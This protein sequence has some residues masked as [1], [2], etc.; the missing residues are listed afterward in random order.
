VNCWKIRIHHPGLCFAAGDTTSWRWWRWYCLLQGCFPPLLR[1]IP[2]AA[3]VLWG[4]IPAPFQHALP[5]NIKSL[6]NLL[7]SV[8]RRMVGA[9]RNSASI[10]LRRKFILYISHIVRFWFFGTC[11]EFPLLTQ[12]FSHYLPHFLNC[13]EVFT[14]SL[15]AVCF[16]GKLRA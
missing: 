15:K 9:L 11:P 12:F 14:F 1:C 8:A 4:I 10:H 3:A 6:P 2:V 5:V 7:V 16:L 13:C